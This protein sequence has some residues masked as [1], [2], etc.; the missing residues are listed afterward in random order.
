[1]KAGD[2]VYLS[3]ENLNLPKDWA[4]KLIPLYIGPL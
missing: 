2:L 4:Q 3:T 1:M